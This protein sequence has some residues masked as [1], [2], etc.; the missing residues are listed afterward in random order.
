MLKRTALEKSLKTLGIKK[1]GIVLLHSSVVSLGP[2]EGDAQGV[3][4]AFLNVL[5]PTGTLVVPVFGRLGIITD[6]M[7]ARKDAVI[8]D[9]PV[10]T[11]AAVGGR[12]KELMADHMKADT[13]HGYGSPFWKIAE[14][15]G[16]ICLLGVDMD[17][18]TMLHSVEALLELPYLTSTE[19]TGVDQYGN[20]VTRTWKFYPGPHRDFIGLD[21]MLRLEGIT[22]MARIGNAQV[23]LIDAKAMMEALLEVGSDDPAFCLCLNP[24]CADCV[25]QRAALYKAT[26]ANESF[27]V[28]AAASLCGRYVPEMIEK[29]DAA[30]I[31]RIELDYIQGVAA[32]SLSPEKLKSAVDELTT[33][34]IEITALRFNALPDDLEKKLDIWKSAGITR[35]VAPLVAASDEV[36]KLFKKAKVQLD[37]TNVGMTAMQVRARL[38][39]ITKGR[40]TPKA[41]AFNPVEFA[42][43]G[44]HPFL[45]S[46]GAGRFIHT[47]AQ[48]DLTDGLWD[49]TPARLAKGN[50]EVW[51]LVSIL[52]CSNFDGYVVLGGGHP[53]PGT[54]KEAAEQLLATLE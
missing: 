24:A 52:R 11:L 3:I 19:R 30:G 50:G 8:S 34:G 47:I 37:Y 14:A 33:A 1:G 12:A 21:A 9:A 46:W 6:L 44:E 20:T 15:G 17:R 5:G 53:Y 26:F 2:V 40:K 7:R 28:A 31:S 36:E 43:A 41:F 23:R 45:R 4:D 32:A 18:N 25:K 29:L 35:V 22:R 10:G 38:A 16:Q 27:K 49:G 13:A 42:K 48:L 39:E 54:L 51:E